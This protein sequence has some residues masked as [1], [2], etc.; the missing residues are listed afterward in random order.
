M[1]HFNFLYKPDVDFEPGKNTSLH[2]TTRAG[3]TTR[4]IEIGTTVRDHSSPM[5]PLL[6]TDNSRAGLED[7]KVKAKK[8]GWTEDQIIYLNKDKHLHL[9]LEQIR[10]FNLS[11]RFFFIANSDYHHYDRLIRALKKSDGSVSEGIHNIPVLQMEDEAHR[12]RDGKDEEF[13]ARHTRLRQLHYILNSHLLFSSATLEKDGFVGNT[14]QLLVGDSY[15]YPTEA[16]NRDITVEEG[17]ALRENG[18]ITPWIPHI[19]SEIHTLPQSLTLIN[20][21]FGTS[22]HQHIVNTLKYCLPTNSKVGILLINRGQIR[23]IAP[24]RLIDDILECKDAQTAIHT[25]YHERGY[26]HIICVGHK[27]AELGQTFADHHGAIWLTTQIIGT[28]ISE[29][30]HDQIYKGYR[31]GYHSLAQWVRT[32]GYTVKGPQTVFMPQRHWQ[33]YVQHSTQMDKIVRE[34][35]DKDWSYDKDKKKL[36]KTYVQRKPDTISIKLSS[37]TV[38]RT[39]SDPNNLPPL[40]LVTDFIPWEG[41]PLTREE[42]KRQ[43]PTNSQYY[44]EYKEPYKISLK[45]VHGMYQAFPEGIRIVK[46]SLREKLEEINQNYLYH[47]FTGMEKE[48]YQT[49]GDFEEVTVIHQ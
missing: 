41:R 6:W 30:I 16:T 45:S 47:T 12:G 28:S 46:H 49:H 8:Y 31:M 29:K 44:V 39:I 17:R 9:F 24:G 34:V 19:L 23:E 32:G 48:K 21:V 4:K 43:Y 15:V 25:M 37:N 26:R 40:T 14:N 36:V 13:A 18:D 11:D 5:I 42:F 20:G 2:A 1:Y 3:K 33:S 38:S 35:I 22:E 7:A 27:Q 10:G